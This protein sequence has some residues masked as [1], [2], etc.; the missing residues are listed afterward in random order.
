MEVDGQFQTHRFCPQQ[1]VPGAL[2]TG[3]WVDPR[4]IFGLL[5]KNTVYHCFRGT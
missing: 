5:K 2:C 1:K 4:S 3:G